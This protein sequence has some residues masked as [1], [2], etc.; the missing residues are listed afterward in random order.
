MAGHSGPAS[1]G[2]DDMALGRARGV[3]LL[4]VCAMAAALALAVDVRSP[5]TAAGRAAPP[6]S[7]R[8]AADA[9][10]TV[11]GR[12]PRR[13][14]VVRIDRRVG[15]R[16]VLV[17]RTRSHHH[18]YAA[19]VALTAGSVARLK[20]T[21]GRHS[22]VFTALAPA[23]AATARP[24]KPQPTQYDACGA[25]PQKADG[26]LWSCTFH[27]DFDGTA[28]DSTKW[29]PM[30][31]FVTGDKDAGFA[32][33]VNSPNNISVGGG[34]LTLTLRKEATAQPCGSTTSTVS[35]SYTS[36]SVS[37]YH[38]FSQQY[39]RY[40][41]RIRNTATSAQGLHE[42]FWLWQDDQDTT[43]DPGNTGE[44]DV[45]ETYSQ[46]DSLAV[47]FL[48]YAAAPSP[49]PGVNT[50]YCSAERGVWNTY[51]LEWTPTT[52]T[53]LVNGHTCLVNTS[54]DP[55]F[56]HRYIVNLTQ[57]LGSGTNTLTDATPI[58]ATMDV[59]YVRVWQ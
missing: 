42:A 57:A 27:D 7:V 43:V 4:L 16:W 39:G 46:Y 48:H 53:V 49:Q 14:A 54:A 1:V 20:V 37:T 38:L 58:P 29:V 50:A 22:R 3:A 19:T 41:A 12:T 52:I 47:P 21:S 30:T 11:S 24:P 55:V 23:A 56:H 25:R 28:L 8:Q 45:S 6:A 59:D 18:R 51:T 31:A 15:A 26:T 35:S 5:A 34:M 9:A 36:G 2:E 44:I 13:S 10:V 17:A 33:Y 40:E 32:C